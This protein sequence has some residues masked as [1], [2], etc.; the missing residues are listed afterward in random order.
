M[1]LTS[2]VSIISPMKSQITIHNHLLTSH[3]YAIT[4]SL[5][6]RQ[7]LNCQ[8]HNRAYLSSASLDAGKASSIVMATLFVLSLALL[9]LL[10]KGVPLRPLVALVLGAEGEHV[11]CP[12][13]QLSQAE[14][15]ERWY[16]VEN[17]EQ[18]L[19]QDGDG[20][21]KPTV[22]HIEGPASSAHSL[23]ATNTKGEESVE[24]WRLD[25]VRQPFLQFANPV[26]LLVQPGLLIDECGVHTTQPK[27]LP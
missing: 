1:E 8:E 15:N 12:L 27:L 21:S 5:S 11:A 19:I 16:Q 6:R 17:V 20:K 13:E 25:D 10:V 9:Q 23:F 24:S 2:A 3:R 4:F 14:A 26:L 7:K 18:R 22:Q